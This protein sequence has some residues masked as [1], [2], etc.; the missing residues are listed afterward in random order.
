MY[1]RTILFT[2]STLLIIAA[3]RTIN[4]SAINKLNEG[5]IIGGSEV[6]VTAVPYQVSIQNTFGEHICGGSIIAPQ[7]I[8]TAGHCMEWP[9]KYLKIVTG[10]SQ[11]KSPGVAYSVDYIKV[12]CKYNQPMY[13]NDIALVHLSQPIVY[14]TRTAPLQLTTKNLLKSG[15]DLLL[16]GWGGIKAWGNPVNKLNKVTVDYMDFQTCLKMVKNN[17]FVGEG[18]LCTSTKDGRGAC[19]YD[20]GSPLVDPSTQMQVGIVNGG[21]PCALG[22]PDTFASVAYYNDWIVNTMADMSAC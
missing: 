16:T 6:D 14:D 13:H 8:L 15:D 17:Q 9:K 22:Y 2:T 10:T 4:P 11:W 7:W 12:H 3:A 1:C 19:T 18:H 20:S 21:E 5:R